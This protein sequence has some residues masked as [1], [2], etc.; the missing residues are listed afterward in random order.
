MAASKKAKAAPE[1]V[2]VQEIDNV[3]KEMPKKKILIP[4]QDTEMRKFPTLQQAHIVGK[5]V[6]GTAYE[7]EET[8]GGR[9]GW[10]YKLTNGRY[11]VKEGNYIIKEV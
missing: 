6:S 10:F 3:E 11:V 9:Y 5:A 7:I 2:Q 4:Q 1:T 8:I